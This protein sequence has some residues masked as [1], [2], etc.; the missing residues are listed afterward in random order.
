MEA[1]FPGTLMLLK[2]NKRRR[3]VGSQKMGGP[4]RRHE[5]IIGAR[6][7]ISSGR[8]RTCHTLATKERDMHVLKGETGRNRRG[9]VEENKETAKKKVVKA[10]GRRSGPMKAEEALNQRTGY[11]KKPRDRMS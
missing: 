3:S 2:G 9:F 4:V 6:E 1:H 10:W 11:D 8:R 7:G 5:G